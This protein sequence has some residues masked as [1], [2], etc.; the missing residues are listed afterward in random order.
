MD[1][2]PEQHDQHDTAAIPTAPQPAPWP[3][4]EVAAIEAACRATVART[5]RLADQPDPAG[6]AA[7][8]T[9]DGRLERPSGELLVGRAAIEAA[10]AARPAQRL[11]RHLL[12]GT[13]VE[14]SAPDAARALSTVLLC[15]GNLGDPPGRYGR[16]MDGPMVVGEFD[17]ELRRE[18]DGQW[19]I[20]HRRASFLLHRS[21]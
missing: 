15:S 21:G 1:A 7:W 8:F 19:R 4:A 16:P 2:T 17:D 6:L 11:T 5:A 3:P 13:V 14:V 9:E 20:T 18:P 10:Y 12:G